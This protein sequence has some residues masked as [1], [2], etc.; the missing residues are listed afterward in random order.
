[1]NSDFQNIEEYITQQQPSLQNKL[2]QLRELILDVV[3]IS[4]KE[5]I[6]YKMPTFRLNGNLIHFAQFKN[7]IGIYPGPDAIEKYKTEL[8]SYKTSK[9]AIQIPNNLPLD[10]ELIQNIV[11][12]NVE[13]MKDKKQMDWTAYRDK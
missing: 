9:G 8:S 11:L 1:M 4:T 10:K 2:N 3:P 7:H 13:E 5:T 6:A 12:F